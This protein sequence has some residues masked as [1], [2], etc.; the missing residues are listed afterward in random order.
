[1]YAKCG[2]ITVLRNARFFPVENYRRSA[3]ALKTIADLRAASCAT[4]LLLGLIFRY[5]VV[6]IIAN[7]HHTLGGAHLYVNSSNLVGLI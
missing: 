2:F 7:L 1:M 6:C 3:V 4:P 5:D